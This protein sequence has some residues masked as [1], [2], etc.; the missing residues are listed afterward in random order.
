M[1]V[2][3][4]CAAALVLEDVVLG[5]SVTAAVAGTVDWLQQQQ[6]QEQEGTAAAA[7][8]HAVPVA[9]WGEVALQLLRAAELA[10]L[11][12]LEAAGILGRNCHLPNS[13]T[14]PL[15]VLLHLEHQRWQ[16]QGG[17]G[18][19]QQRSANPE[20]LD[21]PPQAP[22]AAP[23][24]ASD[25][26]FCLPCSMGSGSACAPPNRQSAAGRAVLA[27]G[28]RQQQLRQGPATLPEDAFVEAARLAI[29]QELKVNS[30]SACLAKYKLHACQNEPCYSSQ[31]KAF[32]PL[33]QARRLLC[34]PRWFRSRAGGGAGGWS[35][36]A[37]SG[38]DSQDDGL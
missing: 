28:M 35:R 6:Q 5:A 34:Q 16:Q 20:L 12:P 4:G 7:A 27:A 30:C 18:E 10:P 25:G 24:D 21:A 11:P 19:G 17:L 38:M 23:S 29:R 26:H 13:L 31:H 37:P 33:V 8:S 2:A 15:Q 3:Y 22:P 32:I 14:T 9:L 1:A 36:Q